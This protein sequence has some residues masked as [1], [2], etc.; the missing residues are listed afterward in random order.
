MKVYCP[1]CGSGTEYSL[2]KPQYCGGCGSA[3]ASISKVPAKR[4]FKTAPNNPIAMVQEEVEEDEFQAPN[5]EKLDIELIGSSMPSNIHKI[6][7]IVGKDSGGVS[8][9]G[10]TRETD[11]TYSKDSIA[12][13]FLRDAG[14]S[15]R[16]TDNAQT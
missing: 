2:K 4:V 16:S 14:S 5:M 1:S 13:D 6:E 8:D 15:S 9:D 7:D 12:A 3:F 10:Y 11:T